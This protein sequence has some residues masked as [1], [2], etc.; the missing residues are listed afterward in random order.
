MIVSLS[1]TES[2]TA[3]ILSSVTQTLAHNKEASASPILVDL[4]LVLAPSANYTIYLST[5]TAL[6]EE[7][8]LVC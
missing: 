2:P 5:V 4:P 6:A 1:L 7:I 8:L 3:P